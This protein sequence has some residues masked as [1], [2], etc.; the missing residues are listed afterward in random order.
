M[1][2]TIQPYTVADAY[3][4]RKFKIMTS[5]KKNSATARLLLATAIALCGACEPLPKQIFERD[6]IGVNV[7]IVGDSVENIGITAY[8]GHIEAARE[9]RLSFEA[10]G[11]ITEMP[12]RTGE[13]VTK[14]QQ[15]AHTDDQQLRRAYEGLKASEALALTNFN[16]LDTIFRKGSIAEIKMLEAKTQFENAH[17]AKR[18]VEAQLLKTSLVAPFDGRVVNKFLEV[19]TVAGPGAPVIHLADLSSLK[20]VIFVSEYEINNFNRGDRATITSLVTDSLRVEGIVDEVAL[21]ASPAS[22]DY[23]V[24]I[25]LIKPS[26]RLLPGMACKVNFQ[27]PPRRLGEDKAKQ[28]VIPSYAVRNEDNQPFVFL[29]APNTSTAKRQNVVTGTFH[30]SGTVI[31]SGLAVGDSLIVSA[32]AG[33]HDGALIQ[34]K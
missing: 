8:S 19:G 33:L 2:L 12:V 23:V 26:Q 32:G 27:P 21:M 13:Y 10:G 3:C 15:L 17:S 4:L 7:F 16:R 29:V 14:G 30:G 1:P 25:K 5:M 11:T 28:I 20:A 34:T 22:P 31:Q 6:T 18:A 9:V 24:K